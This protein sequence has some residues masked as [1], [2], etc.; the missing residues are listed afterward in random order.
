MNSEK[1]PSGTYER[2]YKEPTAD[3]VGAVIIET[4]NAAKIDIIIV[5]MCGGDPPL[6][7]VD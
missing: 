4:D 2:Q 7:K 5:Q 6:K 3:D 1:R